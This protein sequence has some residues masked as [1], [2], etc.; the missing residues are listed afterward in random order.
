M[1]TWPS[2]VNNKFYGLDATP[3]ENREQVKYKSGRTIYYK[4][5]SAQKVTH[6]VLL[7]VN[8]SI[9]DL[10]NKTE[11]IRLIE[12]YEATAGSGTVPVTL[13]DL[14]T[15]TGTKD[16]FVTIGGWS[17]QRF[18]ELTLTLEEC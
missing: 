14:E 18:K 17:G 15:K 5:N 2:N 12:W 8:D 7:R 13:T 3:E 4:K 11:F 10:N 6:A 1:A 16:Y 9:K